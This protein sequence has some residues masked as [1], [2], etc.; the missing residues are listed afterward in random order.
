MHIPV[1]S[2]AFGYLFEFL[3][4]ISC[5]QY[6][7]ALFL[8][9]LIIKILLFPLGIKQQK[10]SVKQAKLRPREM[11]IRNKY[12]GRNDKATQQ[13]QSEEIMKLY[14]E[15]NFNPMSGCLPLLLQMP[16]LFALYDVIRNPMTYILRMKEETV[17]ALAKA[18]NEAKILATQA[19]ASKTAAEIEKIVK[20]LD[21]E[22]LSFK[23]INQIDLIKHI[24]GNADFAELVPDMDMVETLVDSF[25]LGNFDLTV[26][27]QEAFKSGESWGI[28][29]II[30]VL[31]FVFSFLSTKIIRK[32]TYQPQPQTQDPSSKASLAMMDWMMP[33]MSVW[34]STIVS[35]AIGVYWMFQNIL[36]VGQQIALYKMFPIPEITEEE[37]KAAELQLKGKNSKNKNKPV[38]LSN[39]DID[40]YD[41]TVDEP[42][43]ETKGKN[44]KKKDA[45]LSEKKSGISPKVKEKI[46]ETGRPLKAR[47]KI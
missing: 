47:R 28:Y 45:V 29:L 25:M 8:F 3:Y 27:L 26:V 20:A 14:Q 38:V 11:A 16:I 46:K 22:K 37:I 43:K 32:F 7:L 10:N 18:V 36:S 44:E 5:N 24:S 33:L 40:D 15:E 6:L 23:T 17:L 2:P 19:D 30:P 31:T 4:N 9:A 34:I 21:P 12:K 41:K 42:K 1:I 13:K 39:D 35:G